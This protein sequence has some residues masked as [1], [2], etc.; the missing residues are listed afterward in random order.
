MSAVSK[1]RFFIPDELGGIDLKGFLSL[2]KFLG[3]KLNFWI[4]EEILRW[5]EVI[6]VGSQW[7][8]RIRGSMLA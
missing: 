4:L 8:N 7:K 5:K 3:N 1:I 6:K 2:E